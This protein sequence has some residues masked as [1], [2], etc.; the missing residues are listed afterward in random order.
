[1]PEE[2]EEWV[3]LVNEEIICVCMCVYICVC[4][5]VCVFTCVLSLVCQSCPT[6]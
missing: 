4:V 5:C 2:F 3:T 1:M 6:L